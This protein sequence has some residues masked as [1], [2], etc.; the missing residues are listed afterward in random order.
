MPGLGYFKLDEPYWSEE[1]APECPV[2]GHKARGVSCMNADGGDDKPGP[3]YLNVCIE[4]GE[5]GIF[6][7]AEKP[8]C[9]IIRQ[10]T[11]SEIMDYCDSPAY[12]QAVQ[13]S[14]IIRGAAAVAH[15]HGYK[16]AGI[17]GAK[18]W[19]PLTYQNN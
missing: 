12:R 6:D 13:A 4:C 15:E 2:C 14:K 18:I 10:M 1:D 3:G 9:L 11:L 17:F 16:L 8:G 5:V 7:N 19:V